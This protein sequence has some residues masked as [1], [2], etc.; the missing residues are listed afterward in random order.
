[1]QVV[2]EVFGES[3]SFPSSFC[4]RLVG[5]RVMKHVYRYGH[6]TRHRQWHA[7]IAYNF[8]KITWLSVIICIGPYRVEHDTGIHT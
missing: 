5:V 4:V 6:R 1:V 7:D 8:K 3:P 2:K